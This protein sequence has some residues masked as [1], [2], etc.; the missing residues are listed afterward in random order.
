MWIR[1]SIQCHVD[2]SNSSCENVQLESPQ[3]MEPNEAYACATKQNQAYER[4]IISS[5]QVN[6]AQTITLKPNE[7]YESVA[8]NPIIIYEEVV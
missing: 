5:G 4:T 2:Q 8:N 3:F 7:A 1:L 6:P